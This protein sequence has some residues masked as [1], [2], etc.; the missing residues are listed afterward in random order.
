MRFAFLASS[1]AALALLSGCGS[2][3]A[4]PADGAWFVSLVS[5]TGQCNLADIMSKTGSVTDQSKQ[6]TIENA[7]SNVTIEC[8]VTQGTGNSFAVSATGEDPTASTGSNLT[9]NIASLSPSATQANPATGTVTFSSPQT[10]NDEFA[11]SSC[12]FYFSSKSEGVAL[13]QVWVT[14]DCPMLEN[15]TG[16]MSVCDL[17]QGFAIFENCL[18]M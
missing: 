15:R 3:S 5:D 11:S 8:S 9:L 17:K 7:M 13:G 12:N 10:V 2:S 4:P 16:T 6:S 14:F 18:T 1:A